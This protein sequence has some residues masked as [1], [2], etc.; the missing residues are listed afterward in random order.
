MKLL[1][2]N[3]LDDIRKIKNHLSHNLDDFSDFLNGDNSDD[4]LINEC[5]YTLKNNNIDNICFLTGTKDNKLVK[6][7]IYNLG[8]KPFIKSVENHA[9][10][11]L[12]AETITIFTNNKSNLENLG[13]EFIG[14]IDGKNAWLKDKQSLKEMDKI[15]K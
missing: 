5:T 11:D 7:S 15:I 6:A 3:N 1:V 13:F 2:A 8:E 10:N 4:N 14:D 9:F 12:E